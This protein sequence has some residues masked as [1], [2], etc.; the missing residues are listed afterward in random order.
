MLGTPTRLVEARD[1]YQSGPRNVSDDQ[2]AEQDTAGWL[3]GQNASIGHA[4]GS[5]SRTS[6][7][8]GPSGASVQVS[9]DD[10]LTRR[11]AEQWVAPYLR[12]RSP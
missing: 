10:D 9:I 12:P 3:A 6:P 1:L 8:V 2:F 4:D 7:R 5:G 11:Q